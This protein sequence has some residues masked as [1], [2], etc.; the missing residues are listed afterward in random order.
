M[1]SGREIAR[2]LRAAYL[3]MHRQ[4]NDCFVRDGVTADQF[5]LLS[6]LA[7][8]DAVTQQELVRR[9]DLASNVLLLLRPT[10]MRIG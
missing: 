2:A 9:N 8:A 10:G 5:A 6:A 3:A 4:T 7:D 1:T